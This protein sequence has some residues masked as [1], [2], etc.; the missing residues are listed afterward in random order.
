MSNDYAEIYERDVGAFTARS[1]ETTFLDQMFRDHGAGVTRVVDIAGGPGSHILELARMGY[2]CAAVDID[3]DLLAIVGRTAAEHGLPVSVHPV[4]MRR[5]RLDGTYDAALNLFL[6]FQNVL[7]EPEEQMCFLRG[8]AALLAPGGLFVI[9][10]LPEENSLRRHPPGQRFPIHSARQ[11]DGSTLTVTSTNR[12]VSDTAK[13]IVLLY[14]TVRPDGSVE[15]EEIVSP[16]RRVY[17][18]E[19]AA[20][21][22]A[23]GFQQVAAFGACDPGVPFAEDSNKLVAV[24]RKPA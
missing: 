22:E 10:L 21:C 4:D 18:D 6:S 7:F 20:L 3:P 17:L 8:V 19:F 16:I 5:F 13:D 2:R 23:A 24:L 12:I 11:Q 14:E 15:R 9:E 1:R